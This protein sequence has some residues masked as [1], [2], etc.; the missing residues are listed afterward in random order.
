MDHPFGYLIEEAG[1]RQRA[2]DSAIQSLGD[3]AAQDPQSVVTWAEFYLAF[4]RPPAP[5]ADVER[6]A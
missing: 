3:R 4:L 2:L 1:L 6:A 5:P